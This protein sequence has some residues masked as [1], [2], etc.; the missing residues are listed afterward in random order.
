MDKHTF[1]QSNQTDSE[2]DIGLEP[3]HKNETLSHKE[4]RQIV[5]PYAFFVAD[6]LLGTPLAAPFR[7]G[8]GMLIDLFCIALLTQISSLI[9]AAITAWTFF[10]AGNRLKTKKR[11]NAGRIF[12]RLLVTL[13]LFIVAVGIFDE[14]ND[15]NTSN[16][17]LP[18]PSA[19]IDD[20]SRGVELIALTASY[21]LDTKTMKQQVTQGE[22]E[23]AFDCF[24]TLGQEL[25]GDMVDI[26]LNKN[27]VD[28]ALE[29][30]L[31]SVSEILSAS[32]QT[33]LTNQLQQFVESKQIVKINDKTS[34]VVPDNHNVE[35]Q[36]T[37]TQSKGFINWLENAVEELGLGLGWAALYFSVFTAWWKGQTPG[38]RLL[39]MKVI[40]L[41]NSYL[42][43]WDSFGRYG[44]YAAGLAT[45][46]MGFLQVFWDPNRQAIHDKISGT[47]VIDL[48]KPKVPFINK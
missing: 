28:K 42:N 45:G 11:F 39:G 48:R 6:D 22:C 15:N 16:D 26:G 36:K 37:Y 9:L 35:N 38:K 44:G 8:F 12:L 20:T 46:L 14:I 23:P 4:T 1:L 7:R 24:Q 13:L 17:N 2:L 29:R 32:Q 25:V 10:K 40:K 41:D 31:Q 21:L 34:S 18:D 43:L 27:I 30:Y 47:L 19:N 3:S 33:E 5:T